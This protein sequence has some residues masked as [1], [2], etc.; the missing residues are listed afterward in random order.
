MSPALKGKETPL[1]WALPRSP[2][3]SAQS[4]PPLRDLEGDVGC[5]GWRCA[6]HLCAWGSLLSSTGRCCQLPRSRPKDQSLA[7]TRPQPRF[8]LTSGR[9][10]TG[11]FSPCTCHGPLSAW[12]DSSFKDGSPVGYTFPSRFSSPKTSPFSFELG[13]AKPPSESRRGKESNTGDV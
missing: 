3:G 10:L 7:Q 12:G 11:F 13:N 5:P 2:R 4:A 9:N 8:S 6:R 1:S